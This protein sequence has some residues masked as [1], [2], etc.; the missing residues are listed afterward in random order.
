MVRLRDCD[1]L[2]EDHVVGLS[3]CDWSTKGHGV[4]LRDC[5]WLRNGHVVR[6]RDCNW[7]RDGHVVGLRDCDLASDVLLFACCNESIR[8]AM[9]CTYINKDDKT[10]GLNSSP[11]PMSQLLQL[12]K[13]VKE[14][15]LDKTT[16]LCSDLKQCID[17]NLVDH[18][19]INIPSYDCSQG[20]IF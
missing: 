2:R 14:K 17:R 11:P 8:A 4:G 13:E 18:F 12:K 9:S 3:D 1:W 20:L 16:N 15:K 7:L 5:D 6:L 10:H 19:L